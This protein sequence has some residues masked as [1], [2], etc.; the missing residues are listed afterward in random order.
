MIKA[1]SPIRGNPASP[2]QSVEYLS[3]RQ[4]AQIANVSQKTIKRRIAD[5][6]LNATRLGTRGGRGPLRIRRSE[7]FAYLEAKCAS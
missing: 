3:V 4:A 2:S 5:G 6:L 7:L 1:L